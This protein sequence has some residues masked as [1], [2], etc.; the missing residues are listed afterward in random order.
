MILK[1]EK[2]QETC[3][4]NYEKIGG[5][6]AAA[7]EPNW[8]NVLLNIS[9]VLNNDRR[10]QEL[11]FTSF[12]SK[13]TALSLAMHNEDHGASS[14]LLAPWGIKPATSSFP[15]SLAF[16][17]VQWCKSHQRNPERGDR[18]ACSTVPWRLSENC[19]SLQAS[20]RCLK[21]S[22]AASGNQ[23]S[24]YFNRSATEKFTHM[25]SYQP[26]KEN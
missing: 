2:P 12:T 9:F 6:G 14:F 13:A 16:S 4:D 19:P 11:R 7:G 5:D 25:R 23:G 20:H 22:Y 17:A 18:S 26:E 21:E 10:K 15:L 1:S 8:S 24:Y 3:S